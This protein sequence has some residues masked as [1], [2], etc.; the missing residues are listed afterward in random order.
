M[1][2]THPEYAGKT[3]I[4][5]VMTLEDSGRQAIVIVSL[6]NAGIVLD[7]PSYDSV[8]AVSFSPD[9]AEDTGRMLMK[10]AALARENDES[11][12]NREGS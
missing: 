10:M 5:S 1:A 12:R 9:N 7:F 2:S 8:P 6:E 11:R 3:E 4:T